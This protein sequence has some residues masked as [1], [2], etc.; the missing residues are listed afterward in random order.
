MQGMSS[1]ARAQQE[2]LRLKYVDS[3]PDK[4][5]R[6]KRNWADVQSG[7]WRTDG[8]ARLKLEVHRLAGSAG[9]YGLDEL[10]GCAARLD[11][12]LTSGVVTSGQ[13]RII[14]DL[15]HDLLLA[16]DAAVERSRLESSR[17]TGSETGSDC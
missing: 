5:D 12:T 4:R 10:S 8:V 17:A 14:T 16:L 9:S 3:L 11:G 2:R 1:K 13:C 6:I 15:V 7:G